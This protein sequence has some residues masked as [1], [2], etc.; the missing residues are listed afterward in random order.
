VIRLPYFLSTQML[1]TGV[2]RDSADLV[3]GD[4]IN[5]SSSQL[6]MVP[7]DLF[8]LSGDAIVNESML[9]GESVPVSK[10]PI[11]DGD[12]AR[13]RDGL[14]DENPKSMLYNGTKIVR[15][16]GAVAS[17]GQDMP[18][19]ALV[20]R[21]GDSFHSFNVILLTESHKGSIPRREH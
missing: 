9:T 10:I 15:I 3:P 16:R 2:E 7:A 14:K 18:S 20:V 21:T 13:W 19:L 5:L 11:K 12:L 6:S 17:E 4:V 8:L 1:G